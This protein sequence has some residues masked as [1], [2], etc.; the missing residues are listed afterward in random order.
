MKGGGGI[1]CKLCS[2]LCRWLNSTKNAHMQIHSSE[3][4]ESFI[5]KNQTTYNIEGDR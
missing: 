4:L 2:S 5:R 3:T 1:F